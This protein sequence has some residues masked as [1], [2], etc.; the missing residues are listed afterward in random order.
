MNLLDFINYTKKNILLLGSQTC[1]VLS[2][3]VHFSKFVKSL[4]ILAY[5]YIQKKTKKKQIFGQ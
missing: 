1:A 5:T 4:E 2:D 3:F